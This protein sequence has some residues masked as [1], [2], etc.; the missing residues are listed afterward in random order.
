[1]KRFGFVIAITGL[2]WLA[3]GFAQAAPSSGAALAAHVCSACH[4]PQG[5]SLTSAFPK[6]AGQG[7]TYI[8]RQ[9]YDFKSGKR[10]NA[11]M[12]AMA[13]SLTPAEIRSVAHYFSK[14]TMSPGFANPKLVA[15]GQKIFRG[16]LPK[17]QVPACMACHGPTGMGN[18]P[19]GYPRI[20][21]QWSAYIYRQLED[22][23][24]GRRKSP[25]S[26]MNYVASHLKPAQM[27]AVASY[28][29]GLH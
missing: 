27:K 22:F 15:L 7:A 2:I 3:P 29:E 9:L 20:A 28:V 26:M 21:G 14:Q 4:G 11:I 1:M 25:H 10:Q 13:S 23:A 12:Q 5:N 18:E 8:Q 19:A 16:G 24:H 17:Q 6:L